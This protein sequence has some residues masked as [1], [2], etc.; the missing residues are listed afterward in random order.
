MV[1][2]TEVTLLR[3]HDPRFPCANFVEQLIKLADFA[4]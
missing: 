4:A 3:T 2:P 1:E